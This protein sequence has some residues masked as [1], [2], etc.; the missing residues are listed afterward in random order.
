[1]VVVGEGAPH[2]DGLCREAAIGER[3]HDRP[4]G[5]HDAREIAQHLDRLRE[6]LDRH[7]FDVGDRNVV[8]VLDETRIP[9]EREIRRFVDPAE[10]VR[11]CPSARAI[12]ISV[13]RASAASCSV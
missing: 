11:Q 8:D 2:G 3:D 5:A 13:S 10:R 9:I 6:I 1:M 12:A 4:G 7:A